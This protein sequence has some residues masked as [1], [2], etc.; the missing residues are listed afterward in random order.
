MSNVYTPNAWVNGS[1]PAINQSN[2]NNVENGVV[3]NNRQDLAVIHN[4]AT[5]AD[6]TLTADQ[7]QYGTITI[8]DTG[9]VL[10]G[11]VNIIV[12]TDEHTYVLVNDTAQTLTVK[13]LA[14]TG[15]AIAAGEAKQLR[16]DGTNV[17]EFQGG[18]GAAGGK[19]L[20]SIPI[21][22]TD[23]FTTSSGAFI[24][25]TGVTVDIT[26]VSAS[27]TVKITLSTTLSNT[28]TN[29]GIHIR[30]LRDATPIALGDAAGSRIQATAAAFVSNN[31][32]PRNVSFTFTDT[33]ATTSQVTYKIQIRATTGTAT[34]NRAGADV[35]NATYPRTITTITAEEIGA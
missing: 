32:D 8:T 13:T 28:T 5:D 15:I 23:T 35:D 14:G 3:S 27:N 20:Q 2:L 9:V 10:N 24:D 25:I 6:Y 22:K 12:N 31:A 30:L 7:N 18:G 11:G 1:A 29:G 26:P 16:N 19:I 4:I 34:V 33:P 17:I 21:N